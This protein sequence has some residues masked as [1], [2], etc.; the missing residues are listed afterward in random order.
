MTPFS[1]I[2]GCSMVVL[3]FNTAIAQESTPPITI[4]K[5]TTWIV[6]PIRPDGRVNYVEALN[7]Q[8]REGVTTDNNSAVMFR[9]AFGHR[10]LK[11]ETADEYFRQLGIEVLPKDGHYLLNLDDFLN[12]LEPSPSPA[13]IASR[14]EQRRSLYQQC[15]EARSRP[16]TRDEFPFIARWI[17]ANDA[18]LKFVIE[19]SQ[20]TKY[21]APLL[22]AVNS[23]LAAFSSDSAQMRE[24]A[25]LLGVRAMLNLGEG[26]LED[27]W[28]DVLAI[29]RLARFIA[30][31]PGIV[32]FLIGS[33]IESFVSRCDE[34]IARQGTMN[35]EFAAKCLREFEQ[36]EVI[37]GLA[38][39]IDVD[40]RYEYLDT[41][42]YLS[43][44]DEEYL[45]Q[46]NFRFYFVG[47][48][49]LAEF[50]RSRLIERSLDV[51]NLLKTGNQWF[52]RYAKAARL[53]TRTAR[54]AEIEKLDSEWQAVLD[55]LKNIP[56]TETNFTREESSRM[57]ATAFLSVP[58]S[59]VKRV[60]DTMDSCAMRTE[61]SHCVF[62]LAAWRADQG[63]YPNELTELS[64]TYLK[65]IPIDRFNGYAQHGREL[66]GC[67]SPVR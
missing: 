67:K 37:D 16:W 1:L 11:A 55:G 39:R 4:S 8:L 59:I 15:N 26:R 56:Q 42:Q 22:P 32:G 2:P 30:P 3:L 20:R 49:T 14:Y 43:R 21:F 7:Q 40:G 29:H 33:A 19:G 5:E 62:A 58:F 27:A 45:R 10:G 13:V 54:T 63:Q 35:A 34:Q 12:S 52:D 48:K 61:L 18:P 6:S 25:E 51:D 65:T 60:F 28:S 66:M 38:D 24:A 50:V 57:V 23:S 44:R 46:F 17:D 31:G 53:P 36:M 47:D 9:R 64:P 41:I